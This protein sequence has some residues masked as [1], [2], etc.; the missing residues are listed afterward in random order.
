MIFVGTTLSPTITEPLII[1]EDPHKGWSKNVNLFSHTS[2][3]L[4]GDS[5]VHMN[6]YN[7]KGARVFDSRFP[8]ILLSYLKTCNPAN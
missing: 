7:P 8:L 1:T 3:D 5:N 2:F 6:A 4:N